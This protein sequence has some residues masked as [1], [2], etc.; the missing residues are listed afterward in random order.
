VLDYSP[1]QVE[2]LHAAAMRIGAEEA[3]LALQTTFA[4]V[5]PTMSKDGQA[6]YNKLQKQL[7]EL[8]QIT[9]LPCRGGL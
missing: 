5:A 8:T 2:L 1:A 3:L 6:I 9:G 4:G 7:S